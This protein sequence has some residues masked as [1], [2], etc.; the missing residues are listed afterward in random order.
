MRG[1]DD[2]GIN[3]DHQ[4]QENITMPG[5]NGSGP[6]GMGSMTGRGAGRCA[7]GS[8]RQ[9]QAYPRAGWG[10]GM[11]YG[12]GRGF[13]AGGGRQGRSFRRGGGMRLGGYQAPYGYPEAYTPPNPE[14]EKQTLANQAKS[15][16]AELDWIQKRLGDIETPSSDQS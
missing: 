12:G 2:K 15:L 7:S 1:P 14:I 4:H 13:G 5:R 16:Q 9:G 3:T 10:C 8:A 11:G 6:M